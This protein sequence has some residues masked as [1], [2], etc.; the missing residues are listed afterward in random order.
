MTLSRRM[1]PQVLALVAPLDPEPSGVAASSLDSVSWARGAVG[2]RC[3]QTAPDSI[4]SFV[5]PYYIPVAVPVLGSCIL[6]SGQFWVWL[7]LSISSLRVT[8]VASTFW[9]ASHMVARLLST[10]LSLFPFWRALLLKGWGSSW[11]GP[12]CGCR[13]S[14]PPLCPWWSS[15]EDS[16]SS[17]NAGSPGG[18]PGSLCSLSTSRYS[19][20]SSSLE[21]SGPTS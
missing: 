1:P 21:V 12:C 3:L 2:G 14:L 7:N 8:T 18:D 9:W 15:R 4:S 17:S 13:C 5:P 20:C 6:T 19:S 11:M 16:T 10:K